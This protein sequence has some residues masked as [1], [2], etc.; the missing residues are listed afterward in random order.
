MLITA[1]DALQFVI[2]LPQMIGLTCIHAVLILLLGAGIHRHQE[3][4]QRHH[5][6]QPGSDQD[7]EGGRVRDE[8]EGQPE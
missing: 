8:E 2:C 3:L 4:L 1:L 5:A 6:Q 7:A